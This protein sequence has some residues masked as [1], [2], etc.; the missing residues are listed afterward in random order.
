M[1]DTKD[2]SRPSWQLSSVFAGLVL[3]SAVAFY[4][5][6]EHLQHTLGV[7][8][9]AL[10]LIPCLFMHRFMHSGHRPSAPTPTIRADSDAE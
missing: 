8:P 10:F 3:V 2:S 1:S 4:L 7:L 6:T 5:L 9:Y